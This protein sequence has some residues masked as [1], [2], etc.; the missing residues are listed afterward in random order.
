[1]YKKKLKICRTVRQ[2]LLYKGSLWDLNG[3]FVGLCGTIFYFT[4]LLK[5][6][7]I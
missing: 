2:T 5:Q 3:I 1:M 4:C 6:L 7:I